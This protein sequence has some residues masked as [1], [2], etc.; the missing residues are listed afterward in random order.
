[1]FNCFWEKGKQ[2]LHTASK[3][4]KHLIRRHNRLQLEDI[5]NY[6][7]NEKMLHVIRSNW[8]KKK[9]KTKFLILLV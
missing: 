4:Q 5:E 3:C 1:M 7:P 8:E 6:L 2:F 9:I